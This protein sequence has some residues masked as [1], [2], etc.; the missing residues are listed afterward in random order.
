M[1]AKKKKVTKGLEIKTHFTDGEIHPFEL[2]DWERRDA[3]IIGK[4]GK[5]IF[6]QKD[7]NVPVFWSDH[8]LS[9]VCSKYFRGA[10]QTRESGVDEMITRVAGMI[11]K[12]G[13]RQG[14]FQ[15]NADAQNFNYELC[16]LLVHQMMSFNSPVWFNLGVK[17]KPQT[18]ACFILSVEDNME[19]ISANVVVEMKIF[20]W[21]SGCGSNRSALRGSM[22]SIS[23]GGVAS[24]PVSFI[25]IYDQA[26]GTV[27]SAGKMRRAAKMEILNDN[28]PDIFD[29]IDSKVVEERRA[30]DLIEV[31]Y[32]PE[33]AYDAVDLQNTNTAVRVTDEF[34]Q[35]VLDD[36]DW[37]T[38]LI[39]S[40]HE[41]K[42]FKAK[43]L[44]MKIAEALHFCGDPGI[45][46]DTTINKYHTC[47]ESGK[48]YS[49]NPCGEFMFVDNS[50]CNLASLNLMKFRASD[51]SLKINDFIN[52]V[53]ITTI[54]QDILIDNSSF[55]TPEIT[56]NSRV[57]RPLGLG[58]TNIGSFVISNGYPY[59][60]KESCILGGAIASLLTSQAYATSR[61]MANALEPFSEYEKNK[62]AFLGVLKIHQS[63]SIKL[64][65]EMEEVF[66]PR[67][68][69]NSRVWNPIL[70]AANSNWNSIINHPR[71]G[72]RNAQTTL[73]APTGTI[74]FMMDAETTGIEPPLDIVVT[75]SL[76]GG[77]VLKLL[78]KAYTLALEKLGYD[79]SE[80]DDIE[81]RLKDRVKIKDLPLKAREHEDL[82]ST[83]I[84]EKTI[85]PQDH[86]IFMAY[87]QKFFSGAI[88]KT[89][90][91]PKDTDP[92][93]IYELFI[94]AWKLGLK[95]VTLYRDGSKWLQPLKASGDSR[96]PLKWGE[97]RKLP[98]N[99]ASI[100][101]EFSVAGRKGFLHI[102]HF[103]DGSPGEIFIRIA[104]EGSLTSGVLDMA[105]TAVSFALQYG[106][107]LEKLVGKFA[108]TRY[109]PA[110]M[111][112]N[113]KIRIAQSIGDYIFRHLGQEYLE[114]TEL[115][116]EDLV[117]VPSEVKSL[118]WAK[119]QET[120]KELE[121]VANEYQD[122]PIC[123]K[124]DTQ[125]RR[126]GNC[127]LCNNCGETSGVCN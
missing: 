93:E 12:W 21:G 84:G 75:K 106:C 101:H 3:V 49:S 81:K 108:W 58:L 32:T 87:M 55:P 94:Q 78:S 80:I 39:V 99:R 76:V 41:Y 82:F 105:A 14:Y 11:T 23:E 68:A 42:V 62:E 96:K 66:C 52:A 85:N 116:E 31:G 91:L 112:K 110:G 107:P 30:H 48:I 120:V 28:H 22:E 4:A 2:I 6:E 40:G 121:K 54:A 64:Y 88:S 119:Q 29:F 89:V 74:S 117:T 124:C 24:G 16:Y 51:G 47:K 18:S 104:K 98:T 46:F 65:A 13:K 73:L 86:L 113:P 111:T 95:S 63:D 79:T 100:C 118:S 69:P 70:D 27:K 102:G 20:R 127:F 90:N 60:S 25:R 34:M 10:G 83:A 45:Q 36:T 109:E 114:D 9:I 26:A 59:G 44:L 33:E 35:H 61:E 72:F 50:A 126:S 5:T 43:D 53:R 57:F 38:K 115:Q 103:E 122:S 125:M 67:N 17:E 1:V 77:G 7:V 56:H 123:P 71:S 19:H 92:E 15:S 37:A 8:A 97:R